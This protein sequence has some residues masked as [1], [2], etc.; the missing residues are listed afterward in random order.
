M[1][2][3]ISEKNPKPFKITN[4]IEKTFCTG[5][6][7]T[8]LAKMSVN[9]A[10]TFVMALK[11]QPIIFPVSPCPHQLYRKEDIFCN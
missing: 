11:S 5:L 10:S 3:L 9:C 4:T 7:N 8:S 6:R 2:R 1:F